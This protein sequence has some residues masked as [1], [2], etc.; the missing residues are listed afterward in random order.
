MSQRKLS[1]SSLR[2]KKVGEKSGKDIKRVIPR[3]CNQPEENNLSHIVDVVYGLR[4]SCVD[5]HFL[6]LLL[7]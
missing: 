1:H 5:Q 2:E 7:E 3:G 6:H 4:T